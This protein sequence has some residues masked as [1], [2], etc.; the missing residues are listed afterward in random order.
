MGDEAKPPEK[1][2]ESKCYEAKE[3]GMYF[4]ADMQHLK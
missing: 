3:K 1:Y 4:K 2:N